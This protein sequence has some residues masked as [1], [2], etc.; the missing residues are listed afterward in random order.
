MAH[1]TWKNALEDFEDLLADVDSEKGGQEN[2]GE[3]FRI[4]DQ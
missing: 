3:G 4:H 2:G 1:D